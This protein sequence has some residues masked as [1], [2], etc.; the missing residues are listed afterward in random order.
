LLAYAYGSVAAGCLSP[1]SDVDVALVLSDEGLT[2]R[3]QLG[4]QLQLSVELADAGI[5][6]ADVRIINQPGS[7]GLGWPGEPGRE[8]CSIQG[9]RQPG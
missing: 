9:M 3:E 4:L 5:A 8:S 2:P 6:E 1:F 7:P